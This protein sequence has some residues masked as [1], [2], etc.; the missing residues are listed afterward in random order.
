MRGGLRQKNPNED[1]FVTLKNSPRNVISG[2]RYIRNSLFPN[3]LSPVSVCYPN[4]NFEIVISELRYIRSLKTLQPNFENVT[5]E[6]WKRYIRTLETLYSNFGN[7]I[8]GLWKRYIRTL[9]ENYIRTFDRY[10]RT[11][12]RVDFSAIKLN[13]L[14]EQKSGQFRV[15]WKKTTHC[16]S[17]AFFLKGKGADLKHVDLKLATQQLTLKPLLGNFLMRNVF[18]LPTGC[19]NCCWGLFLDCPM[20]TEE[21]FNISRQLHR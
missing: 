18:V 12:I 8:C 10:I 2:I 16:N 20:R 7:V 17:R 19:D 1:L 13:I 9:T 6:L 3:V 15:N 4:P 21:T 11:K 14:N 5:A